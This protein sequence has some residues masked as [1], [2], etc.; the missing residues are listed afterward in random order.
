MLCRQFVIMFETEN[1]MSADHDRK[2]KKQNRKINNR[3]VC[4]VNILSF[5]CMFYLLLNFRE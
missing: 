5:W 4:Y 2:R 1:P 3:F